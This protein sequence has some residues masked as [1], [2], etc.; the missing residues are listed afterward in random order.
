[1]ESEGV[2]GQGTIVAPWVKDHATIAM[3]GKIQSH[4][5]EVLVEYVADGACFG[6]GEGPASGIGVAARSTG[7]AD[8]VPEVIVVPV[9]VDSG[10]EGAPGVGVG[11][12]SLAPETILDLD[13]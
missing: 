3:H 10:A 13:N 7:D 9:A 5:V 12:T 6:F 4:A 8:S 2:V 11:G 1:M